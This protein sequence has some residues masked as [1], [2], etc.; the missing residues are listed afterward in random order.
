MVKHIF[1]QQVIGS[2][3][4]NDSLEETQK[5]QFNGVQGDRCRPKETVVHHR[6]DIGNRDGDLYALLSSAQQNVD[7][8]D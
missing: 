2:L 1:F 6:P 4:S 3:L 5:L 7:R 8:N